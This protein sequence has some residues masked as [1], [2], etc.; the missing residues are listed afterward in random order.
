MKGFC[1]AAALQF[2][3]DIRS[4]ALFI[5]CYLV[6]LVFFGLMGGIFTSLDPNA[7]TTLLPSMT[8]MG[9]SMG[10]LI[11]LPPTLSELYGSNVKKSYQVG[12]MP[13]CLGVL[14]AAFSTF[15]H[16]MLLGGILYFAAPL[17]FDAALPAHPAEYF[18]ALALLIAVTLSI[19]CAL[20][21]A[22]KHQSE[23]T[24][25]CQ[26]FFLPSILLSGILVPVELLPT[27]LAEL[28]MLFPAYW[29]Y[30]SMQESGLNWNNL[31]PLFAIL[32][33]AIAVCSILLCR[34]R[35]R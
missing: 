22:V 17:A 4:K 18:L 15:C 12:G 9:V 21:L 33:A 24:M 2:R 27:P 7:K 35:R 29:G 23:L 11:G 13:L 1:Y 20:G 25:V 31:W 19:G 14:T 8:V 5:T 10:A 26:I 28:G 30:W 16:L 34:I 6:P 32:L 3:L